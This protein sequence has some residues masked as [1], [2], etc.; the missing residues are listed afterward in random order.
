MLELQGEESWKTQAI[1]VVLLLIPDC[2]QK[3]E[4]DC[5]LEAQGF[6]C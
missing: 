3:A 4:E 6:L 5:H 1:E 2:P